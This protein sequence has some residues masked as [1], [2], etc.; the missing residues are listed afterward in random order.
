MPRGTPCLGASQ[1][2]FTKLSGNMSRTS[3]PGRY[4]FP[5]LSRAND[6]FQIYASKHTA[7]PGILADLPSA[8]SGRV[9]QIF[10]ASADSR[11]S[12]KT[13]LVTV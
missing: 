3:H 1:R 7:R 8:G 12:G 2:R 6:S 5:S 11:C 13:S 9:A 4:T 10:R